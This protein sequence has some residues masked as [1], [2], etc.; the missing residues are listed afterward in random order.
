[1]NY[2]PVDA[3]R[4]TVEQ[5]ARGELIRIPARRQ[6]FA[7]LFLPVWLAL[8]TVG[9]IAAISAVMTQFQI[10]L[11]IWLCGWA[12]GW[13][14]AAGTLLWMIAGSETL[15]AIGGDLEISHHAFGFSRTWVYQGSQINNLAPSAQTPWPFQFQWQVPFI[16]TMRTGALK[17]NY[18]PRT[19][20]AGA[21]LDEGEAIM[22]VN[23]LAHFLPSAPAR[24]P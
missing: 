13:V 11:V 23:R 2:V 7:M 14:F 17:F 8:W 15:L 18:G 3:E 10:F 21:G 6:I 4:F 22:V 24:R 5:T 16:R 19:V 12:A 1:M 20:Y 9:G